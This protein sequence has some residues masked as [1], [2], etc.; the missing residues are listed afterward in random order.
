MTEMT[1]LWP[2]LA[3]RLA[4]K[5]LHMID[6]CV[7]RMGM[8]MINLT[9][10]VAEV[11]MSNSPMIRSRPIPLGWYLNGQWKRFMG[12]NYVEA[13]CDKFIK[14]DREWKNFAYELPTVSLYQCFITVT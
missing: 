13:M 5:L 7:A 14:D 8:I 3:G 1:D 4:S 12:S 9:N 2:D 6:L 10:P 11:G